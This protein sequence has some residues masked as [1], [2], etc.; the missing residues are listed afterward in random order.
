MAINNK[1]YQPLQAISIRAKEDL[2]AFRFVSHLGTVCIDGT[3]SLGVTEVDWLKDEMASV[4]TLGTMP[5]ETTTSIDIGDN[6]TSANEGKARKA[7]SNDT[8]NARA[9]DATDGS[10]F[11]RVILVP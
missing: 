8:I 1:T 9:L 2:S 5:V 6:I 3:K 4:I 11:I 10:G 7:N